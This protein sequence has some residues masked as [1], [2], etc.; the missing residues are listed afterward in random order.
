MNIEVYGLDDCTYCQLIR[1]ALKKANL[2]W[3][4]NH[5]DVQ[6]FQKVYPGKEYPSVIIDG[7]C[8]GGAPALINY[9][10]EKKLI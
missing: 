10:T 5:M 6:D 1:H 7:D 4:E 3:S 9:L 2:P 8:I